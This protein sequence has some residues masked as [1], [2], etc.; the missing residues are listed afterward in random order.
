MK[1]ALKKAQVPINMIMGEGTTSSRNERGQLLLDPLVFG[2]GVDGR[3]KEGRSEK[4]GP[5]A[6]QEAFGTE[7]GRERFVGDPSSTPVKLN[8]V[9]G[10][11]NS[12]PN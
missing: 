9:E 6:P 12:L 8:P 5:I 2:R 10:L 3:P 7:P 11:P 1:K 4:R